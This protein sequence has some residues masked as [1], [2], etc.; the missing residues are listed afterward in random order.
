VPDI[1]FG[2]AERTNAAILAVCT[3][4]ADGV[5][6]RFIE[7]LARRVLLPWDKRCYVH[8]EQ[9]AKSARLAGGAVMHAVGRVRADAT[10]V[11]SHDLLQYVW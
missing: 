10:K 11:L 4:A 3:Q 6:S 1:S 9:L 2:N 7:F 8:V 5:G